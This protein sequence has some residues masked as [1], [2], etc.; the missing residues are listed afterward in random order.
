MDERR[1]AATV[2]L[3]QLGAAPPATPGDPLDAD[4][5]WALTLA[6]TTDDRD[7][8]GQAARHLVER[9]TTDQQAHVLVGVADALVALSPTRRPAGRSHG[10]AAEGD[11]PFRRL[12]H[13]PGRCGASEVR[14]A[15]SEEAAVLGALVRRSPDMWDSVNAGVVTD[16]ARAVARGLPVPGAS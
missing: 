12:R 5:R 10:P 13:D 6:E 14:P 2:L 9:I 4:A 7:I 1:Q 8:R 16:L 3:A 11:Q 15:A